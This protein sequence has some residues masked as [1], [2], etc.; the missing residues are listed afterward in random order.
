MIEW[1]VRPGL[2]P[3][4]AALADM[5]AR[6]AAITAGEAGERLLFLEHPPLYTAGTSARAQDLLAPDRFPVF[7]AGRGGEYTYHGPGQRIVYPSLDLRERGRDVRRYVQTLEQWIIDALGRV[8]IVGELRDGRVGVW[9]DRNG[10]DAKVAAIGVRIRR[11]VTL[12][13]L[14]VNVSPQLDHFSGIVP[15]G[16]TYPVTSLAELGV[17]VTMAEFDEHLRATCPWDTLY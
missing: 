6:A 13:G 8:G 7:S 16:L 5:E 2:T 17:A 1:D 4:P 15:C 9:V 12:H 14:S 11:W 3:Y 10:T